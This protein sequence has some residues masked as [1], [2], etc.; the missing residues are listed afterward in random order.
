M[1]P[2]GGV[3]GSG[4]EPMWGGAGCRER[5]A[6]A[7]QAVSGAARGGDFWHFLGAAGV[8]LTALLAGNPRAPATRAL[9]VSAAMAKWGQGDPR[10]IVEERE[11]GTNVNNWHWCGG[12]RA[13]AGGR[14]PGRAARRRCTAAG[15]GRRFLT[16]LVLRLQAPPE[17]WAEP[18]EG[19]LSHPADSCASVAPHPALLGPELRSA[20]ACADRAASVCSRKGRDLDLTFFALSQF[21]LVLCPLCVSGISGDVCLSGGRWG[22]L[23]EAV[24]RAE[25]SLH[26]KMTW[27]S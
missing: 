6:G 2:I 5:A 17:S 23:R 27:L 7:G 8:R 4:V 18:R 26:Q 9:V 19:P 12:P 14:A 1:W 21:A 10:W 20:R 25:P 13:R 11:D 15:G 24:P 22:K 3:T 16:A